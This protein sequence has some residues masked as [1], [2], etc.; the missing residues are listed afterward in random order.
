MMSNAEMDELDREMDQPHQLENGTG[1][2]SYIERS[3][4]SALRSAL[5]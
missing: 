3:S 2:P 1:I 4:R 5:D